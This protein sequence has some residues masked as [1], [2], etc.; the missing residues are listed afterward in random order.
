MIA[1]RPQPTESRP[2]PRPRPRTNITVSMWYLKLIREPV[3]L[4][5]LPVGKVYLSI[6]TYIPQPTSGLCTWVAFST[7][8]ARNA[9]RLTGVPY[10][11][12][13]EYLVLSES[14]STC[15]SILGKTS[16]HDGTM[17][18]RLLTGCGRRYSRC[19]KRTDK[20]SGVECRTT[21]YP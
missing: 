14:T 10:T 20:C 8:C 16:T 13:Y 2:R 21:W 17:M 1:S 5:Y 6:M 4:P 12:T 3:R 19:A 7:T 15:T 9:S 11:R 18:A